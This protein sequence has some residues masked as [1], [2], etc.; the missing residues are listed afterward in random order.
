MP[1]KTDLKQS[2]SYGVSVAGPYLQEFPGTP[3]TQLVQTVC[4]CRLSADLERLQADSKAAES[5]LHGEVQ[6]AESKAHLAQ[7]D[8]ERQ[9]AA[10]DKERRYSATKDQVRAVAR[11]D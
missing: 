8:A 6:R 11:E 10:L 9:K 7:A 2:L 3:M 1:S 4:S 5:R